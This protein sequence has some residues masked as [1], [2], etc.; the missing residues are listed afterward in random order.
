MAEKVKFSEKLIE[1]KTDSSLEAAFENKSIIAFWITVKEEYSEL[2]CKALN[3][4]LPITI[5]VLVERAF[6][7]YTFIK[8]KYR[9]K[10]SVSSDLRVYLSSVEPNFKK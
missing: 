9:N 4:L 7:T 1:L 6:S 5:T 2:S 3:V 10:V 8:N